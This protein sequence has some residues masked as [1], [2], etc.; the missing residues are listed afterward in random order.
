MSVLAVRTAL[1]YLGESETHE[2]RGDFPRLQDGHVAHDLRDLHRLRS[3]E[4]PL[5]LRC[6][7]LEE[8][9]DDLFEVLAEFVKRGPLR[10]CT[11][12]PRDVADE[13]PCG[14]VALND[15]RANAAVRLAASNAEVDAGSSELPTPGS[16]SV[17][18]ISRMACRGPGW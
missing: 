3:D 13:Q 2:N 18:P 9:C 1:A 4:L 7:V 5:E 11:R 15:R 16:S 12:P 10:V 6:A 14:L 17:A 8:H